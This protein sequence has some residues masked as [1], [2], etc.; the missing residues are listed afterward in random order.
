M[1]KKQLP[2]TKQ[3]N[4]RSPRKG[5][6]KSVQPV[7]VKPKRPRVPKRPKFQVDDPARRFRELFQDRQFG[8]KKTEKFAHLRLAAIEASRTLLPFNETNT[9]P[10]TLGN[11]NWIELGPT[12]VPN[13]QT[14]A[15]TYG[16]TRVLVSGR[17]TE[18][19]QHPTNPLIIY[20]ASARGGVWKTID[21]G[22]TWAPTSDNEASLAIG[23][24][25]ISK[26]NP[27]VLYAGTGEG[28]IYYYRITYPLI[29]VNASYEGVGVLKS[30]DGGASWILQGHLQFTGSCFYKIAV[31]PTNHNIAFGATNQGLFRTTNGGGTW[32]KLTNGLPPIS[33]TIVACCDVVIHPTSPN[34]AYCAFWAKG[35]YK[36]TNA[37]AATPTWT[38]LA[39]GLPTS[40]PP[41]TPPLPPY[42]LQR[43]SLA[44]SPTAPN[45]V[46]AMIAKAYGSVESFGGFYTSA[47]DG[48]SWNLAS[49]ALIQVI[50]AYTS[51]VFVD[52]S[53]PDIVYLSGLSLYKATRTS[54]TWSVSDVGKNIH[55]DNHAFAGHPTNPLIIYAGTDGG[56]Y[57][58]TDRGSS[59][60]DSINKG[61]NI[62]QFEFLGQHPTSDAEAIGGTQDNGTQ[63]FRN[64][65]AFYHCADSD[66]GQAGIDATAPQNVIHTYYSPYTAWLERSTQGGKF[67]SYADISG[68]LVGQ[69]LFF[70][71]WAYDDANSHNLAL[72]TDRIN[73]DSAQGTGGWATKVTLPGI[74]GEVSAIHY[75]NSSL[76][77]AATS[78]GQVYRLSHAASWTATLIGKSPALPARWIWDVSALPS[79]PNTV[80]VVM[81]GFGTA[82]VWKGVGV[83]PTFTPSPGATSAARVPLVSRTCQ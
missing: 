5:L 31:H 73:L 55:G 47:N 33:S 38:L 8:S 48:M 46:Y 74:S 6:T 53:T 1:P 4:K 36:T 79:N 62:M 32:T 37:S 41:T 81:A 71:P 65:P 17:V 54:G 51:N 69:A 72:G 63:M 77:Y 16:G 39:G 78:S 57:K 58:S 76:I 59:W 67:G 43:I 75:V 34:I 35:I 80:I 7:A 64:H 3:T 25:A 18:I 9:T 23:A 28:D 61:M 45:N 42:S 22:V 60:D 13:G 14:I 10:A 21:G 52:I 30:N 66:G 82:H 40:F 12:A 15:S 24:L 68:G 49:S 44:I 27:Q 70:P 11:S 83:G 56:I 26:S 50:A 2:A 20:L 29:S 19:V